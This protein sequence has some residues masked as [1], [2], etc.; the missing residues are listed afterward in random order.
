M[1]DLVG[2][3]EDRFSRVEAHFFHDLAMAKYFYGHSP[4]SAD[5]KRA[6]FCYFSDERNVHKVLVA[7]HLE[8]CPETV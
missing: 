2:N 6:L 5:S 7:C 8:T 4:S 1:S 3:P